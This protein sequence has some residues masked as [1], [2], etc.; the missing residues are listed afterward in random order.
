[1]DQEVIFD[2][3][4][5]VTGI[6]SFRS[7]DLIKIDDEIMLIQNIGVGQTN[8]FKVLRAQM[9]TGVATHANG[10][11]VQRLG[12]NYNIVDNTVHFTS[13]HHSVEFQLE[14]IRQVLIM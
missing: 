2:V 8:N 1:M 5:E 7:N 4:F 9:G 12:G 6:T 11:T 3:D 10:S 14:Q 13:K